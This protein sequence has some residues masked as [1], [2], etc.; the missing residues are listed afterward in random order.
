MKTY[1]LI[2]KRRTIRS[3]LQ[4]KI[5]KNILIRCMNAGRLAP[6]SANLQPLEYILV[7]KD[8]AEVFKHIHWAGYLERWNPKKGSEPTA[9]IFILSNT[10]IS[11]DSKYDVG[12][13]STNIILTALEEGISSCILGALDRDKLSKILKVPEDYKIELAIALGYSNQE[14][15]EE[16]FNGDVKYWVDK[17]NN[18]H[19]P[20]RNKK[21]IFNF[22]VF[23][24]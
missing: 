12:L 19:V 2:L 17:N 13:T 22:E 6:S 20:K 10:K 5:N 18:F 15:T 16:E 11:N 8:L 7:T 14:S 24:N 3:F 1:D 21:D 9:Y 23:E 4:R